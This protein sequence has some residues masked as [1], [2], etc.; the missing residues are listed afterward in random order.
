[1]IKSRKKQR[2]HNQPKTLKDNLKTSEKSLES[3]EI[4]IKGI[5]IR[6]QIMSLKQG[7]WKKALNL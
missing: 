7:K 1:M 6:F 3:R 5:K 4:T 2:K